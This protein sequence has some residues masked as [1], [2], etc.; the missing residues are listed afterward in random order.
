MPN[1]SPDEKLQLEFNRWAE[2]GGDVVDL[3]TK[4]R[5]MLRLPPEGPIT[6]RSAI[7]AL[8]RMQLGTL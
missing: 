2:Q 5:E 8:H 6:L 1:P 3:G 4:Q 7:E